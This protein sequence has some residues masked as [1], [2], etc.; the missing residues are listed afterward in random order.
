MERKKF[1]QSLLSLGALTSIGSLK[2][3]ESLAGNLPGTDTLMPVL[4]IGHGNPMNAVED[5]PFTNGWKEM[6]KDV[7]TPKAILVISAH[8]ETA[9]GAKVFA[10]Q[11]PKMIYDMYGF[12]QNLYQVQ[13]DCNGNPDLANE[14]GLKVPEI[15]PTHDWGLDHGAWSVL[16]KTYPEASIPCFQLSLNKTRDLQWHY[17]LAKQLAFLRRKGVLI[18]GSGNIVHNLRE[19]RSLNQPVTDWALEFD[20][21][22]ADL[23]QAGDHNPLVNYESLGSS[24]KISVNSAEHYIPLL[25]ALALQEDGERVQFANVN[26][27]Q[28][29]LGAGMRSLKIG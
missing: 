22:V 6:V 11:K 29:L 1:L 27:D 20:A 21:K 16:V 2:S 4:F 5:N 14:I 19:I 10:G 9:G 8:W 7:P 3:L 13:Y 26:L 17:D 15:A 12:P 18:L 25:Y 28:T 24:A 23:I